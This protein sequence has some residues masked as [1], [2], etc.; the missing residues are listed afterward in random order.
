MIVFMLLIRILFIKS[1]SVDIS[2]LEYYF[3]NLAHYTLEGKSIY[4]DPM[5]YPYSNCLY[6]P[7]Y[8]YLYGFILSFSNYNFEQHIHEM[9]VIGRTFSLFTI[10][11]TLFFLKKITDKLWKNTFLN[12]ILIS[13]FFLL[14]T[15]HLYA[16]RPDALKLLFFTLFLYQFLLYL[17]YTKKRMNAVLAILFAI[18]AVYTKQDIAFHIGVSFMLA[19]YL[20]KEKRIYLSFLA[21]ILISLIF[22]I[23][24]LIIKP[25]LIANLFVYNLQTVTDVSNSYNLYF[26]FL[27]I[28][29]TFPLLWITL[30][31]FKKFV[32]NNH[33]FTVEKY[34]ILLTL[35][36]Y[37]LSHLTLLRPGAN[38]NYTYELT[39]L[40]LL[41]LV[42]YT[43]TNKE[44]ILN[45]GIKKA[46]QLSIYLA[47]LLVINIM[48]QTY[49]Y[50]KQLH[51]QTLKR[52]YNN[53]MADRTTIRYIVKDDT[54]FFPN[55]KYAIFYPMQH[56]VLGHDMHL[57][58]FIN[59]YTN[60]YIES[61]L[62]FINTDEYDANFKNGTIQYILID[63]TDKSVLH[64]E[65]Y[66]PEFQYYKT[67][68]Q[69]YVYK[70]KEKEIL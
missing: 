43:K 32:V 60:V 5:S 69:F 62:T 51:E 27:S 10:L 9:L 13:I 47:F 31:N 37:I 38:F 17:F 49:N 65:K 56:I 30:S 41:N 11:L 21:F 35:F 54:I 20:S 67:T 2:G 33:K 6:T 29:R 22:F 44:V 19:C 25:T 52:E 36:L 26:L 59:L 7:I 46:I 3:L 68:L 18:L 34:I 40:L 42:I 48:L 63:K 53:C 55:T 45:S 64:V 8:I 24:A 50:D 16:V 39:V 23:L 66:Y 70:F 61:K 57:D 1:Y 4:T 58:R 14:I 12:I 15:G 28:L